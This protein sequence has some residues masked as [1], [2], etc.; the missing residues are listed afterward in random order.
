MKKVLSILLALTMILAVLAGCSQNKTPAASNDAPASNDAQTPADTKAEEPAQEE[1]AQDPITFAVACPVT[2][3]SAEYGVHFTVGAQM[4]V[5]EINANGGINGRQVQLKIFDSKN[6]AKEATEVARLICE[7]SSILATIGDF[8]STCCMATAPIYQEAGLIQ[9]SPSAGLIDFPQYGSYNFSTTG[10]QSDDGVF[11]ANRVLYEVMGVKSYAVVYTNND[12]GVNFTTYMNEEAASHDITLT[13]SEAITSGEKDFTAV[14]SKMRQ[15][16]PEAVVI[17]GGYTEAANCIKQIRQAGWDVPIAISGAAITQQLA[18]LL[19]DD[20]NG[21][22]SNYSFLPAGENDSEEYKNF[23]E[24]FTKR[25]NLP[26][27]FHSVNT[28]DTTMLVCQAARDCEGELTRESLCKSLAAIKGFSGLMGDVEMN[29]D[30][31]SHRGYRVTVYENGV[32]TG[33]TPYMLAR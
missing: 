30:G 1:A 14:V 17:V 6:D 4:A 18:D 3:D 23:T 8:S 32:L 25:A 11:L 15:T 27:S 28:Y 31:T 24:E 10:L 16:N 19:G 7:D 22:Y 33:V 2:G 5:D 13:D 26:P 21:I 29:E 20:I 12:Y 9:I